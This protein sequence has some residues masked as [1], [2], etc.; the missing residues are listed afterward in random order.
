MTVDSNAGHAMLQAVGRQ[1]FS[2]EVWVY[3]RPVCVG[4][5]VY[6][7]AVYHVFVSVAQL[8]PITIRPPMFHSHKFIYH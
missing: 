2:E 4:F 3:L 6:K 7:V 8:T 5:L 1:S